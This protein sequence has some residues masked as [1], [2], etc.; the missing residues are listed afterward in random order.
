MV[1]VTSGPLFEQLKGALKR[2]IVKKRRVA[3]AQQRAVR[4][5]FKGD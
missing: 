3:H 4:F 5:H 2:F 1:E